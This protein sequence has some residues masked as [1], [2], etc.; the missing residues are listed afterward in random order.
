L[1]QPVGETASERVETARAREREREVI[2]SR[3]QRGEIQEADREK[4]INPKT[5]P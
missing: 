3:E 1:W 5:G 2:E 4:D